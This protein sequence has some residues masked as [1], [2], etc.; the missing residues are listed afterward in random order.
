MEDTD[1]S[2]VVTLEIDRPVPPF[3]GTQIL[4][5]TEIPLAEVFEYLDLQALIAGQWQFRKPQEQS[6]AD[7][8]Q[9]LRENVHPLLEEWK[10]RILT[11]NLLQPQL[12]YGY[13]PCQ[14][15]GNT[16]FVYHPD[17]MTDDAVNIPNITKPIATFHFPRQKANK[18]L[19][20]ADFF[21]T[22]ESGL[23]DVFPLQAVTVGQQATDYANQLFGAD[24][25]RDYLYFHGMA[26]Q[27]AEAMAEW[28]HA[29]IRRELR[30]GHLE[31]DNLRDILQQR[32]QGS[33]YSFGYPACP[34]IQD[35]HQQLAL[36]QA[37]RIG[38]KMDDSDQL[39]PEQSTTA[40]VVYHPMA[41]YFS[42]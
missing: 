8:E 34:N 10:T 36:L 17:L 15:E 5:T 39:E 27:T 30:Y 35:Q 40:I 25:Y 4:N 41:K 12:V 11:E 2:E 26:V 23:M 19:C 13:F 28:V 33:R 20:I 21:T 3:W 38:L 32:Y 18:R 31:P 1:R 7:Y 42:T 14:A 16:L 29:R 9:F 37:D 24:Q 6:K 22:K